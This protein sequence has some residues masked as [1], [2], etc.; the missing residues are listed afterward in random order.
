MKELILVRHGEAEHLT[1]GIVG[2]WTDLP[3]TDK[4]KRQIEL[5]AKRLKELFGTRIEAMYTSDLKRAKDSAKIILEDFAIP[6]S[7]DPQF[8][9]L[10]LGLS[11]DMIREEA[12]KIETPPTKPL[13]DWM[14]L[15]ETYAILDINVLD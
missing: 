8:R 1:K 13:L 3:L 4:G 11:K 2:G 15:P 7:I 9:E 14:P 6:F 10:N 5:T 12:M